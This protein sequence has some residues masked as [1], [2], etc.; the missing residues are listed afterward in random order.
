MYRAGEYLKLYIYRK[1]H[2]GLNQQIHKQ[3]ALQR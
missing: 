2:Y 3:G 1:F